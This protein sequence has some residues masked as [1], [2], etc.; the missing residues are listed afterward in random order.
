[1]AVKEIKKCLKQLQK[2]QLI[3]TKITIGLVY[4]ST[5]IMVLFGG[6]TNLPAQKPTI[7]LTTIIRTL[8]CCLKKG[9]QRSLGKSWCH[10]WRR[11]CEGSK[12]TP[13]INILCVPKQGAVLP[14]LV[15][16]C[17]NPYNKKNPP[18]YGSK[19]GFALKTHW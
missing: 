2:L 16:L 5:R 17:G 4:I 18:T 12:C 3:S 10:H 1:M 14:P 13:C 15:F 8:W 9:T 7:L 19:E 11:Y 6:K